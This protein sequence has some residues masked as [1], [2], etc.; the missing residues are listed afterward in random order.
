[1]LGNIVLDSVPKASIKVLEVQIPLQRP[2]QLRLAAHLD[3]SGQEQV[4]ISTRA[5]CLDGAQQPTIL[6]C[7]VLAETAISCM[8]CSRSAAPAWVMGIDVS[9]PMS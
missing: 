9:P 8:L 7:D 6:H 5:A 4:T 3:F 2:G 1:M